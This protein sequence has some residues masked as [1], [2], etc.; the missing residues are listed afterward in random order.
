MG[1][2][3]ICCLQALEVVP[4]LL[5]SIRVSYARNTS[6]GLNP[7]TRSRVPSF[8]LPGV[9]QREGR[10]SAADGGVGC[11]SAAAR[12][13]EALVDHAPPPKRAAGVASR[14]PPT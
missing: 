9:R 13:G 8:A 11:G 3:C 4:Y 7:Q 6:P 2:A 12:R 14:S 10:R 5:L 1:R